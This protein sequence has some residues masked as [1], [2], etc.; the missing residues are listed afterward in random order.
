MIAL[1]VLPGFTVNSAI[2]TSLDVI[3]CE[4]TLFGGLPFESSPQQERDIRRHCQSLLRGPACCRIGD[5][6]FNLDLSEIDHN[7]NIG[8]LCKD[9]ESRC[10][11]NSCLL[12]I[13]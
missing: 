4:H 13:P 7:I 3:I 9:G 2:S 11:P 10:F 1:V 5:I 12:N 6:F 8:L